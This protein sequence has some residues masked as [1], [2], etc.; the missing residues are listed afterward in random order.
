MTATFALNT[1]KLTLNTPNLALNTPNLALNISKVRKAVFGNTPETLTDIYRQD[2]NMATWQRHLSTPLAK[3]CQTL[4]EET[5]FTRNRLTLSTSGLRKL[6]ENLAELSSFP[7]LIDDIQLLT[8]MFSYLFELEAV[9]LRLTSL[10]DAMC[11]K[12][13][14]DRV[15]CRLITTYAG[16]GTD[17]LPHHTVDRSKLGAGSKG[18]SDVDSGLYK[19]PQAIQS[20]QTGDVALLKGEQWEGNEGAGLVHR[21]PAIDPGQRRLLL[22]LD[23]Q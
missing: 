4:L 7:H 18:P 3:E 5:K 20:L 12:F 1:S 8:D 6:D 16:N 14:V 17:W 15:P 22:T 23:F 21:S 2:V 13:H 11:P 10:A 19:S 9:G